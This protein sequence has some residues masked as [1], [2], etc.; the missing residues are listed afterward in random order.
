MRQL[1]A[2]CVSPLVNAPLPRSV[3]AVD[4]KIVGANLWPP[5]STRG[6]RA[7]TVLLAA[8][9]SSEGPPSTY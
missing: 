3:D 4:Y 1:G 7:T 2:A 9:M 8:R 5:I 6:R